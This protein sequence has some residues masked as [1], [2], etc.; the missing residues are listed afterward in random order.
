MANQ[1]YVQ[2]GYR[3]L[4]VRDRKAQ[5]RPEV[6]PAWEALVALVKQKYP[7]VDLDKRIIQARGYAEESA[8]VHSDGA[9]VDVRVWGLTGAQRREIVRLAR[10]VGFPASWDRAWPNNEHLHLAADIPGKKTRA[11]YQVAAVKDGKNGLGFR[12]RKGPDDG[13]KPSEWR[14]TTTGPQWAATQLGTEI[15]R[16]LDSMDEKKLRKIIREEARTAVRAEKFT[17]VGDKK[18]G[19]YWGTS[20]ANM[21]GHAAAGV[22]RLEAKVDALLKRK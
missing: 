8:G 6:K 11:S 1:S 10:E 2:I 16:F 12:G 5:V 14:N 3:G 17:A 22:Q 13:P 21:A 15:E 19:G 9:A 7:S 20:I 18:H 4:D